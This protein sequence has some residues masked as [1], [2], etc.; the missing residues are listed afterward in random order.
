MFGR[1]ASGGKDVLA[2]RVRQL[3][4]TRPA[5]PEI[6]PPAPTA[7]PAAPART[8]SMTP[9]VAK[10]VRN[11][12]RAPREPMFRTGTLVTNGGGRQSVAVKNVSATGALIEFHTRAELPLYVVLIEPMLRLNKRAR[13]VWQIEGA[14]GLQFMEE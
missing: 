4:E 12:D 11:K 2:A 3:S 13:V 14:A 5:S 1:K 8:F 7:A 6:E 10:T 9:S